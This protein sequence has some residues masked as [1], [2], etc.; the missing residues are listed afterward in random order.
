MGN[1][2]FISPP[3]GK[4]KKNTKHTAMKGNIKMKTRRMIT[5]LLVAAMIFCMSVPAFAD[6]AAKNDSIT[7]NGT[8][9]GE[10]YNLYKMFDLSVN[11]ETN[12]TAYTY[13]VNEDWEG[14]FAEH[15]DLITKDDQ[16]YVTGIEKAEALAKAA[17]KYVK[18]NNI[19]A[20]Q[21]QE[22]DAEAITFSGLDD[23]YYL[24]T[25]TL[26]TLAMTETTPDAESVSVEEKNPEDTIEKEVQEDSTKAWGDQNDAQI[27][28]IVRFRS[29]A[30]LIPNTRNVKILDEMDDGLIY[31][32][33]LM[34]EGLTENEEY[35]IVEND[36]G[37]TVIFTDAYIDG[38]TETTELKLTY[39]AI[40]NQDVVAS[41]DGCEIVPQKNRIK[42]TYGDQQSVEDETE[43]TTHKFSVHKHATG[44][45]D[46]LPGATF[47]LKKNG[48][49]LKL[50]KIDD[51][52]YRI[53]EEDEAGAVETFTTVASGDIVI[54]GVDAD[55]D[56]ALEETEA[57]DGFNKLSGDVAVAVNAANGTRIDVENKSGNELPSTGGI[58]TTIFYVLGGILVA[59]AAILLIT[60]KRMSTKA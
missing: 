2:V 7:V 56:Y 17:A 41:A 53:A 46:N 13:T 52:N 15:A 37:F 59:F 18:D 57:P 51:T 21:S 22:A 4:C 12:P 26:G 25:S 55:E 39:S 9:E 40:L 33:D 23:G 34:I 14:F 32:K 27:G 19:T 54:W 3:Q 16:G 43:T 48:T 24:I 36:D 5:L 58:G 29:T 47:K 10:T 30:T 50:I 6:D 49:D 11:D 44:S 20:L 28:D 38:L 1:T 42:I 35:T 31:N 45:Q 8:V 60:R